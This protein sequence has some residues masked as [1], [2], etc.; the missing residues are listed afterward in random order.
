[1]QKVV[2]TVICNACR[3]GGEFAGGCIRVCVFIS[4][5]MLMCKLCFLLFILLLLLNDGRKTLVTDVVMV[6]H[7]KRHVGVVFQT[8]TAVRVD[9]YCRCGQNGRLLGAHQFRQ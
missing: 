9:G 3:V 8:D 6:A 4:E 5:Y 2:E 1:M 7:R